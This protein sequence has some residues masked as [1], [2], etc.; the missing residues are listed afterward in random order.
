[1]NGQP[2]QRV[3]VVI[4][5]YRDQRMLDRILAALS[6]Q[7]G[8]AGVG[9]GPS[10]REPVGDDPTGHVPVGPMPAGRPSMRVIV[11]DDGSPT[12]PSVPSGRPCP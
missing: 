7:R 4:P 11:A 3:D 6:G 9:I 8:L 2:P 1:M 5:Y 10:V 12:P